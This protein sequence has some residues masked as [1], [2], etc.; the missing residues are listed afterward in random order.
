M[1]QGIDDDDVED[2]D[3]DFGRAIGKESNDNNMKDPIIERKRQGG[4]AN[5]VLVSRGLWDLKKDQVNEQ[6]FC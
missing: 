2:A 6:Q 3:A 5:V 1:F 4:R